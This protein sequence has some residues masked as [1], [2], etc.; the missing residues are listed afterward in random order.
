MPEWHTTYNI[1]VMYK[2]ER[3]R[4]IRRQT[5]T[6]IGISKGIIA[7]GMVNQTEAEFLLNWLQTSETY[8]VESPVVDTLYQRVLESL[9]DGFLDDDEKADLLEALRVFA[10]DKSEQGE[11]IKSAM[12]LNDPQPPVIFTGMSFLWTGTPAYGSRKQCLDEIVA[13]GGVVKT[14]MSKAV[15][16]VVI[17]TYATPRW[18]HESHGGKIQDAVDYRA[19]FGKPAIISE[20]HLIKALKST[21]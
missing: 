2:S 18:K 1:G 7:D 16:Y 20:G 10:G 21:P 3:D 12:P 17:G 5:D 9:E 14:Q 19:R 4:L 15:D 8:V 6:L 13:R 11:L